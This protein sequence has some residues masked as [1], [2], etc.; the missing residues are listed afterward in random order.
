MQDKRIDYLLQAP[1]FTVTRKSDKKKERHSHWNA[2][3]L[4]PTTAEL[5]SSSE[6]YEYKIKMLCWIVSNNDSLTFIK[7]YEE[8]SLLDVYELLMMKKALDYELHD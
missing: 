5:Y 4:I 7:L 3:N 2:F 8:R 1:A 6:E